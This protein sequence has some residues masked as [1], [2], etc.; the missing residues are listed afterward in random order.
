VQITAAS[1]SAWSL[2]LRIP[3]WTRGATVTVNGAAVS[4]VV[5]GTLFEIRRTWANGDTVVVTFPMRF[6]ASMIQDNRAMFQNTSSVMY[7]PLV[8]AGLTDSGYL[9]VQWNNVAN[10]MTRTTQAD[11]RFQA[12]TTS[13]SLVPFVALYP[14]VAERYTVY[15]TT[16]RAIVPYNA[17]GSKIPTEEDG[18]FLCEGGCGVLSNPVLSLRSGGPGETSTASTIYGLQESS[19]RVTSVSLSYQY[20]T[21][22][23]RGLLA[24]RK[25]VHTRRENYLMGLQQSEVQ[26]ADS[27]APLSA[28]FSMYLQNGGGARVTFYQ[29]PALIDFP[30]DVN[31]SQYSPPVP[32]RATLTTPFDVSSYTQIKFLFHNNDRNVQLKLGMSLVVGWN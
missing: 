19:H 4:G 26:S 25:S 6:T 16:N 11:L 18:D 15:F 23:G 7:G 1:A 2:K 10:F 9:D 13:G 3:G 22:Y 28:N 29:S 5:S 14:I 20:I 24:E 27:L 31:P 12:R 32:V 8:L 17:A 21:G 30:Y